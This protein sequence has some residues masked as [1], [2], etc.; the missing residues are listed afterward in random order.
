MH[1]CFKELFTSK[2]PTKSSTPTT[3]KKTAGP[4]NLQVTQSSFSRP[5]EPVPVLAINCTFPCSPCAGAT[6]PNCNFLQAKHADNQPQN[7]SPASFTTPVALTTPTAPVEPTAPF[8][9]KPHL[10]P[11]AIILAG[12]LCGGRHCTPKKQM[13]EDDGQNWGETR[14]KR[15]LGRCKEER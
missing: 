7:A 6:L 4:T 2:R 11:H 12:L 1:I 9:I 5:A 3:I 14:L 15:T 13:R 8:A 10:H